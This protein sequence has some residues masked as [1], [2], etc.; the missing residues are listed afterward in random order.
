MV[1]VRASKLC[2]IYSQN[3]KLLSFMLVSAGGPIIVAGQHGVNHL[4]SNV[5]IVSFTLVGARQLVVS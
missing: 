2:S 1:L 5:K 3:M 4:R